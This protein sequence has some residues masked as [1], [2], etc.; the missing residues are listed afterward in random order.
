VASTTVA[1]LTELAGRLEQQLNNPASF[2]AIVTRVLLRTGVNIREP[3]PD[4]NGDRAL[5]A[6]ATSVLTEMGYRF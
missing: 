4:Q 5:V 6:K 1:G 3:K 2:R